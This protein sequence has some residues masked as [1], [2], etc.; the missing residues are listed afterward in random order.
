ML[1]RALTIT[2]AWMVLCSACDKADHENID[3]WTR[4]Q[5]GPGKLKK[6]LADEDLDPDLSAHAG[7]NLV[8]MTQ[9]NEVRAAL[10]RMSPGR[11][12]QVISKLAPRLWDIARIESE[13]NLPNPPQIMA[14]DALVSLRKSADETQRKQIDG[15]L[16]DWY[17]VSSYE[18]RAG[19]GSNLGASVIRLL[20]PPAGTKLM[21]VANSVIAAP[22]QDKVKNR[23]GDELLLGL[24]ASAHPEAVKYVLDLATMDRGDATLGKRAMT[25]L[26]KTY[27]DP[28]GLFDIASPEPLAANLDAIVAVAKDD[29]QPGQVI[30]DAVALI[31]AVGPPACLPPL[32]GMVQVPHKESRF[33]YV[34]AFNALKCGGPRS[35]V[36]VIRALPDSGAYVRDEL[37]GS[38]S[39]EIARMTPRDQVQVALRELL[40]DKSTI[41]RWVAMEALAAMK[42]TEDAPKIAA[43][44][45]NKERLTGYWGERNPEGKSDPTLGDRAKELVGQLGGPVGAK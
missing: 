12:T 32:L 5:K 31:R 18:A 13:N 11:R 3:K 38:I 30:N 25:A 14:K 1:V 17:A 33:K 44:S 42:S 28:G 19:V 41:A 26:Y 27:V 20:G 36:E 4:T 2:V 21:A 29:A 24:A 8:K 16:I 15:Y 40:A 45:R 22:G 7:A 43:L 34:A 39:G 35:I 10:E 37:Q 9:D 6:A 23:I